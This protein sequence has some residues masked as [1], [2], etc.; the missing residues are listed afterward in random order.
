[1]GDA[2]P[3]DDTANM[4]T[5]KKV[6]TIIYLLGMLGYSIYSMVA[7]AKA[8]FNFS[9]ITGTY[10]NIVNNWQMPIITDFQAL[11]APASCP[12]NYNVM[13]NFP[14]DGTVAGCYC[15]NATGT[16]DTPTNASIT[17]T[18]YQGTCNTTQRN[19]GCGN[20][21]AT[22][23]ITM[24]TYNGFIYCYQTLAGKTFGTLAQYMNDDGTCQSGYY[25]CGGGGATTN[26]L[27]A[28]CIPNGAIAG[29]ACPIMDVSTT[30]VDAT[31]TPTGPVFISRNPNS[32]VSLVSELVF[33][34][35]GVCSG[36][37][38]TKTITTSNFPLNA[39]NYTVCTNFDSTFTKID[40]GVSRKTFFVANGGNLLITPDFNTYFSSTAN[41]AN[42]KRTYFGFQ[43]NCRVE[44]TN[45]INNQ[46]AVN[47]IQGA[48]TGLFVIAV[49]VAFIIGLI[50]TIVEIV[51]ICKCVEGEKRVSCLKCNSSQ[52]WINFVVK[53]IH[54][55]FLI[56]AVAVAGKVRGYFT[57]LATKNCGSSFTNDNLTN[58]A[59]QINTY[60]YQ[61]DLKSLIITSIVIGVDVLLMIFRCC[62][63]K[64]APDTSVQNQGPPPQQMQPMPMQPGQP[65]NPQMQ[66]MQPMQPMMQPQMQPMMQPM[67]PMMQQ[68][69]P[70]QPAPMYPQPPMGGG[71]QAPPP[72]YGMNQG[73]PGMAYNQFAGQ[74]M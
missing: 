47:S 60:V 45:M 69:Y 39:K 63:K 34:E 64:K 58:L 23:A 12:T 32:A 29:N 27:N 71:F 17:K 28:V 62:C 1:M 25:L 37:V 46:G 67:D 30:A 65:Y 20:I 44:V 35:G 40:S 14:W 11:A 8:Y 57:N 74:G 33:N 59:D 43:P 50:F 54:L 52:H 7:A 51:L 41:L 24:N 2:A 10:D 72:G 16:F 73:P 66:P 31:Y 42:Y 3:A 15:V 49:I 53:I 19:L 36:Q 13:T 61:D 6:L 68:G 4:P 18:T 56:W 48:Q 22:N 38:M 21:A 26:K 5:W 55:A 9:N 70:M